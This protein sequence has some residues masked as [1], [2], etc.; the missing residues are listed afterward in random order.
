MKMCRSGLPKNNSNPSLE[1]QAML[2]VEQSSSF[3]SSS[4]RFH[5]DR[6]T[7][8]AKGAAAAPI[9][10]KLK[11]PWQTDFKKRNIQNNTRKVQ[12]CSVDFHCEIPHRCSYTES[13]KEDLW[14]QP[15][16]LKHLRMRAEQ[17]DQCFQAGKEGLLNEEL[18]FLL[19]DDDFPA[20]HQAARASVR[21]VMIEQLQEQREHGLRKK[22][23]KES[24]SSKFSN[25][26]LHEK[27]EQATCGNQ[28][29]AHCRALQL[30]RELRCCEDAASLKT[31]STVGRVMQ[32][33]SL[34]HLKSQK[35]F[36]KQK[37]ELR[38]NARKSSSF[39]NLMARSDCAPCRPTRRSSQTTKNE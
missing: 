35:E 3:T 38:W 25:T 34:D 21:L 26:L 32:R 36:H 29:D 14:Y 31:I 7:R 27:Y 12:F 8:I 24:S 37:E 5:V 19:V 28:L 39:S 18:Q 23:I 30:E 13:E 15:N 10:V 6:D 11:S 17:E 16:H 33:R 4:S 9:D 2:M 22:S 1:E 20:R